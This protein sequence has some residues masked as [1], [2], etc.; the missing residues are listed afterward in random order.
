MVWWLAWGVDRRQ[1]E[2]RLSPDVIFCGWLGSKYHLTIFYNPSVYLAV[3][4]IPN[5][6]PSPLLLFR[7]KSKA[8][9]LRAR[10]RIVP[11]E[12]SML[13]STGTNLSPV[14]SL[15]WILILLIINEKT[16]QIAQRHTKGVVW[17]WI[18]DG[19]M[20]EIQLVSYLVNYFWM[21]RSYF[22]SLCGNCNT[23]WV[24]LLWQYAEHAKLY[25]QTKQHLLACL[26]SLE[27]PRAHPSRGGNVTVYVWHKP[28][29][30]AHSFLFCSCVCLCFDGPFNCISFH[31]F[32]QQLS[33]FPLC[34]SGVISASLVLST[35]YLF[36]K[37]SF[38]PDIIPSGWLD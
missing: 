29:E 24:S 19:A 14:W 1:S 27:S 6:L 2:H 25:P 12:I 17:W 38:S 33:V 31:K 21:F 8:R 22:E 32:Y 26:S 18:F 13:I 11:P 4:V 34:S 28:T 37:V 20:H 5:P 36:M 23:L 16:D 9:S 35:A 15:K 10:F 30:L 7:E 3:Q